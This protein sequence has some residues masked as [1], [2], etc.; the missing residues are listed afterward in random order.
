MKLVLVSVV[1]LYFQVRW[2]KIKMQ[3]NEELLI[4][5]T[6]VVDLSISS[7]KRYL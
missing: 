1:S 6:C 2:F 7:N 4:V 5:F 3:K